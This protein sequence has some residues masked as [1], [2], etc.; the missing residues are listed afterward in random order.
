MK[1]FKERTVLVTG[2]S[3]GLGRDIALRF[4]SE[5][6]SVFVGYRN[7]RD[8]AEEC[9]AGCASLGAEAMPIE[10]DLEDAAAIRT[11]VAG[12]PDLDVLVNNAAV[13]RDQFFLL[14]PDVDDARVI[15]TNLNGTMACIRAALPGMFRRGG[16]VVINV[17]SVA[18][19]NASPGQA[20]YSASKG[21]VIAL[22]R[23]LARELAG[24]GIR[25]NAVAPGIFD[26]G[27]AQRMDHRA[28]EARIQSLPM[29]RVGRSEELA[30]AVAF[31]ASDEASYITGQTLVVDGGLTA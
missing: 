22:T 24:R 28:R 15:A 29:G 6:A 27:M 9:V 26:T 7:R 23:T 17:A 5:G 31:L 14:Q 25:I 1:R 21:G 20:S 13:I 2:A 3:R 19:L 4:A 10:L 30:S 12:L 8:E 11:S 18:G 16:G